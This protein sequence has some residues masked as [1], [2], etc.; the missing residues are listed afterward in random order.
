LYYCINFG[1]HRSAILDRLASVFFESGEQG[2]ELGCE[3]G[4]G[5]ATRRR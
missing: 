1:E 5:E 3:Q 2:R 4:G